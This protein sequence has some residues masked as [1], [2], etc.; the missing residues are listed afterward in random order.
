MKFF[1]Q[2]FCETVQARV[3]K[4]TMQ[5]DN[6]ILYRGIVTSLFIFF[7]PIFVRISFFP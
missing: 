3:A 2:D 5:V 4:F 1:I 7:F 6:D